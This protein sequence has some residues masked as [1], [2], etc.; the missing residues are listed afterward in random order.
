MKIRATGKN[1]VVD[2]VLGVP[3][4]YSKSD[5]ALPEGAKMPDGM[6][7]TDWARV[8]SVGEKC[9]T[10]IGVGDLVVLNANAPRMY[11]AAGHDEFQCIFEEGAILGV[12]EDTEGWT[13][14][15]TREAKKVKVLN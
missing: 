13:Y 9:E 3:D 10:G 4:G 11:K 5:I 2:L 1:V 14:Q 7:P 12:I 6:G 15:D 8:L